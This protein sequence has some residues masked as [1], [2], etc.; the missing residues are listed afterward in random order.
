MSGGERQIECG[1]F[2]ELVF[3]GAGSLTLLQGRQPAVHVSG[4]N[5]LIERVVVRIR[6]LR[7]VISLRVGPNPMALLQNLSESL[8]IVAVTDSVSRVTAQGFASVVLGDGPD[9][10]LEVPELTL[11][12]SGAGSLRGDVSAPTIKIR[13]RGTG[14]M[15]LAGDTRLLDVRM[16]GMGSLDCEELVT[17]TAR[18]SINGMGS[19]SVMVLDELTATLNGM[20]ALRYRGSAVL[21]RRGGNP[22][23]RVEHLD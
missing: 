23:A 13:H 9:A 15:E 19:A 21:K 7:L 12:N 10:P 16:S 1:L 22:T 14:R 4:P 11:I 20:G 8:S 17:Q 2:D 5:D 3:R 6:G 18:I